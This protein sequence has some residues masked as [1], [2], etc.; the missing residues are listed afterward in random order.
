VFGYTRNACPKCTY[1][2]DY[3]ARLSIKTKESTLAYKKKQKDVCA[4]FNSLSLPNLMIEMYE[5]IF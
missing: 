4:Q 1:T 3:I 5:I 2:I